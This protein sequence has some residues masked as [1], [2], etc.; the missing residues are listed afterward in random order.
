MKRNQSLVTMLIVASLAAEVPSSG[1]EALG[2][3]PIHTVLQAVEMASHTMR[4][5]SRAMIAVV[6]GKQCCKLLAVERELQASLEV[7]LSQEVITVWALRAN[8]G[9]AVQRLQAMMDKYKYVFTNWF[10]LYQ[11]CTKQLHGA[12][13]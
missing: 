11:S 8:I 9:D 7:N 4:D 13:P 3:I 1:F 12:M 2:S 6:V 10:T 5:L